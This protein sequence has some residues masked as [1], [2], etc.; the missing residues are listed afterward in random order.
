MITPLPPADLLGLAALAFVL[1]LRHGVDADH[2]AAID[3]MSRFNADSRPALARWTG[4]WFSC[5]HGLVVLG[6]AFGVALMAHA[7]QA[8]AWLEPVGAWSSIAVLLALGVLNLLALRR[9][10][11]AAAV[12]LSG[13]RSA[14]WRRLLRAS[15]PG[16]IAGVGAL[17]AVSFDTLSQAALMAVTGTAAMGLAAVGLLAGAFALGMVVTDG[18]NGWIVVALMRRSRR[19]AAR[20]SRVMALSVSGVSIATALLGAAAQ[21]S[22]GAAAWAEA[23]QGRVTVL[24]VGVVLASFVAALLWRR[25]AARRGVASSD[26][27]G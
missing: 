6:V 26:W 4:V 9:T 22:S 3:V 25:P 12:E 1:G 8:P 2:L 15:G 19:G 5:G 7:W 27:P 17:F 20:A 14:G 11:A 13:W 21:L 10:P 18:L 24:I 23:H 16:A